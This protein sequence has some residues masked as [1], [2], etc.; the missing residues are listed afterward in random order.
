MKRTRGGEPGKGPEMGEV[1]VGRS[2]DGE[3]THHKST[4]SRSSPTMSAGEGFEGFSWQ[5]E[6]YPVSTA[7]GQRTLGP[8]SS[9]NSHLLCDLGPV[10]SPL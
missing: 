8:H 2:R 10:T 1:G 7:S 3:A 4:S 9:S 5:E 6:C